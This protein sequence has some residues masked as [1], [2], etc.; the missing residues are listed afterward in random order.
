MC[1][2]CLL[3][4]LLWCFEF[5]LLLVRHVAVLYLFIAS[6]WWCVAYV[7]CLGLFGLVVVV[8]CM[9]L[10]V[11]FIFILFLVLAFVCFCN[12]DLTCCV[13]CLFVCVEADCC[14]GF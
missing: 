5:V 13:D 6:I 7:G 2:I 9:L 1:G 12:C 4:G 11:L 8:S 10:I 14:G 3:V